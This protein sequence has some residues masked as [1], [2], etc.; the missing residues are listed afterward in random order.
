MDYA[1]EMEAREGGEIV[2]RARD[3]RL[4]WCLCPG[5]TTKHASR[6]KR[7]TRHD[8]WAMDGQDWRISEDLARPGSRG[9]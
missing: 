8:R 3:G 6:N 9:F 4:A 7:R 1:T 5:C 2:Y